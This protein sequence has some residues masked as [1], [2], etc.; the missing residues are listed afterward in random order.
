ME[1]CT[2]KSVDRLLG[3]TNQIEEM[4]GCLEESLENE[5]LRFVGILELIDERGTESCLNHL[6]QRVVR[7]LKRTT[8]RAEQIIE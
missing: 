8:D 7:A 5:P 3:V 2:S 6:L 4:R 1:V